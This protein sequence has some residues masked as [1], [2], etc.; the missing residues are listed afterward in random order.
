MD[1]EYDENES[2]A[3]SAW[4]RTVGMTM[5]DTIKI[6]E[7]YHPEGKGINFNDKLI[8]AISSYQRKF[9]SI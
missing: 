5:N 7:K 2:N 8:R 6:I 4:I 3:K 1:D 9:K